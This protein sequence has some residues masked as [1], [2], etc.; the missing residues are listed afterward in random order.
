[1]KKTKVGMLLL[2]IAMCLCLTACESQDLKKAKECIDDIYE[3]TDKM[4]QIEVD[5]ARLSSK[6]ELSIEED[7]KL[8][9]LENQYE[10]CEKSIEME[11][12]VLE[13]YY[14][15][16]SDK[17]KDV[18]AEYTEEVLDYYIENVISE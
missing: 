1:M 5:I 15:D 10:L 11:Y 4:A 6:S 13:N 9:S 16:L 17:E 3:E 12:D 7:A 18:L 14:D 2:V 8:L